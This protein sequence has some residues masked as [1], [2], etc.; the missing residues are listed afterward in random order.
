MA[1][2]VFGSINMDL[3]VRTP[4]LPA[5]GETLTGYTFFAAPGGKGANQ[6][7]ACARLGAPT[8]MVGRVGDDL[9]GEQLRTSLRSYGVQDDGVL[10]TPGPSGVALIAVDDTA[11]NTIVIVPGA[12]G[13]VSSADIP[14]LEQALDGARTLLLQLEVPIETVV[15]AA[16][17]AHTRG[18]TVILD[19]APALSLPDELYTLADII[20]PNE[21]EATT[22]TGIAV[23]DDQGAIAAA[24]ALIARGA[25]RVAL[26]LGARGALTADAEG[27]QF[28]PPFNV[29]PVDTVAAGDAF[30][31]GLAVALSEGRSFNEAIRWGLA[32]GALSV[33]RYG[34]QPSMPERDEVLTLLA[35]EHL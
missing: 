17:A 23:H 28:W 6:A 35:Q 13:A 27:E 2:V 34:A 11:E 32:A 10:T 22:L 30:N 24:R 25:R 12:N 16:R 5:P 7:V 15:A 31:G 14:R 3:V 9:F 33:T 4:R 21:H 29:T 26:K 8:R 20:T 1:V 18:V 19:P